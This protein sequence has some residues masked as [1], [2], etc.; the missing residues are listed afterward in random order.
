MKDDAL[1]TERTGLTVL[2]DAGTYDF[3]FDSGH[4][5]V[6][7]VVNGFVTGGGGGHTHYQKFGG[8]SPFLGAAPCCIPYRKHGTR[9]ER[10]LEWSDDHS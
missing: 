3:T 7:K 4:E 6:S 2:H 9:I 1:A 5:I 10:C 8:V